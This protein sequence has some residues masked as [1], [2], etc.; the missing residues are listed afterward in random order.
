MRRN[1][2][3]RGLL[4]A[5]FLHLLLWTI[6]LAHPAA[7]GSEYGDIKFSRQA[8]GMDDVAPAV[9]PHWVH[10]MQYKCAACHDELFKMKAGST[11]VTMD[12][13]QAGRQ[14]GACHNGKDAFISN[15]DTCAR[16]HRP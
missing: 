8:A 1:L 6:A 2:K 9:F 11:P 16:C 5:R 7:S 10:R 15:F 13:I 14:C 3:N 12:D 4:A